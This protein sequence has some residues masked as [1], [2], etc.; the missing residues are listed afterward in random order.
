MEFRIPRK[1]RE[2]SESKNEQ[3]TQN[4][5]NKPSVIVTPSVQPR[6]EPKL[7]ELSRNDPDVISTYVPLFTSRLSPGFTDKNRVKILKCWKVQDISRTKMF[8]EFQKS[9]K[10]DGKPSAVSFGFCAIHDH[11]EADLIVKYGMCCDN[12]FIGDLGLA[13]KGVYLN[14]NPDLVVPSPFI[15]PTRL[16]IMA[17]KILKGK[18]K[19]VG[20]Y[21]SKMEPSYGYNSHVPPNPPDR[22]QRHDAFRYNQ[23]YLFDLEPDGEYIKV[24]CNIL[25]YALYYIEYPPCAKVAFKYVHTDLWCGNLRDGQTRFVIEVK[26]SSSGGIFTK[27]PYLE[28]T[29]EIDS[30][31]SMIDCL[32]YDP[33]Q[34]LL[35]PPFVGQLSLKKELYLPKTGLYATYF[36]V[37]PKDSNIEH[38]PLHYAMLNNRLVGWTVLPNDAD[39]YIFPNSLFSS[40]LS[41]P[42]KT[43]PPTFHLIHLSKESLIWGKFENSQIET[44]KFNRP[45]LLEDKVDAFRESI[46]VAAENVFKEQYP[47]HEY[48]LIDKPPVSVTSPPELADTRPASEI[49]VPEDMD[50]ASSDEE[51]EARGWS[52]EDELRSSTN[53]S[54]SLD[55]PS[56]LEKIS[57]SES[58]ALSG[59]NNAAGKAS[60]VSISNAP[61]TLEEIV[62]LARQVDAVNVQRN[63]LL[64]TRDPRIR[65]QLAITKVGI[66]SDATTEKQSTPPPSKSLQ[67]SLSFLRALDVPALETATREMKSKTSAKLRYS[68]SQAISDD[69]TFTSSSPNECEDETREKKVIEADIL[70]DVECKE[71]VTADEDADSDDDLLVIEETPESP[72]NTGRDYYIASGSK[73]NAEE[74]TDEVLKETSDSARLY[75]PPEVPLFARFSSTQQTGTRGRG[76]SAAAASSFGSFLSSEALSTLSASLLGDKNS[77]QNIMPAVSQSETT[78][79]SQCIP[80]L[81]KVNIPTSL[82]AV[83]PT[84]VE[85]KSSVSK[86]HWITIHPQPSSLLSMESC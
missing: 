38:V 31:I 3:S 33:I 5:S 25:P 66:S 82:P 40:L 52:I 83:P 73:P 37:A 79:K 29:L 47:N 80:S 71:V 62:K 11:E 10:I 6:A 27:P 68:P 51:T 57:I 74:R 35:S 13:E 44:E 86:S 16:R 85:V 36:T 54:F 2:T 65:K 17:F 43:D 70:E 24:P 55:E 19:V 20:L 64:A 61:A 42:F 21:S 30:F 60:D 46:I 84:S 49:S 23:I 58:R 14:T 72:S 67:E 1:V 32:E 45:P 26:L 4:I 59:P 63:V 15:Q 76:V 56:G 34:E 22:L 7:I 50:I 39:I 9:L 48:P 28:R 41:L 77:Q 12:F 18:S 81:A 53:P 69:D 8:E 78:L 75:R